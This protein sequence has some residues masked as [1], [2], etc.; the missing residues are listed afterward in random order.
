[1]RNAPG[2]RRILFATNKLHPPGQTINR[3]ATRLR[4][5]VRRVDEYTVYSMLL[6]SP[7]SSFNSHLGTV[8]SEVFLGLYS[9]RAPE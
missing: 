7:E 9:E 4:M 1:M 2:K 8:L 5:D 6:Y 3:R